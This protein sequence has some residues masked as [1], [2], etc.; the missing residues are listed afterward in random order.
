MKFNVSA[1]KTVYNNMASEKIY[2]NS[3]IIQYPIIS[4]FFKQNILN[5]Y[6]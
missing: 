4:S 1:A 2:D 3:L 6:N 5:K